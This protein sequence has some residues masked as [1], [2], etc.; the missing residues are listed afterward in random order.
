MVEPLRGMAGD[1]RREMLLSAINAAPF[2]RG[3]AMPSCRPDKNEGADQVFFTIA[4][5]GGSFKP[6]VPLIK[7][8]G[9]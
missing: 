3:G 6:V 1:P 2:D 9:P 5:A 4:Q 7:M 8:V